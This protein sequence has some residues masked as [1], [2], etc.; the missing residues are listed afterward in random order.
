MHTRTMKATITVDSGGRLCRRELACQATRSAADRRACRPR[1]NADRPRPGPLAGRVRRT[2][3]AARASVHLA[4]RAHVVLTALLVEVLLEAWIQELLAH[5]S[6]EL[7]G[8]VLGEVPGWPKAL[9]NGLILAL[10]A[11]TA[12]KITVHRRW[13]AFT[14]PADTALVFLA[15]SWSSPGTVNDSRPTRRP[16]RSSCIPRGAVAFYAVRALAP[17][18]PQVPASALGRGYR[19]PGITSWSPW[20]SWSSPAR[21]VRASAGST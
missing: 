7:T 15:A 16:R 5:R 20:S 2:V 18:W 17:T 3:D 6:T 1:R 21:I 19:P 9:K 8:R 12:V 11:L 10:V 4:R 14:T 13:R